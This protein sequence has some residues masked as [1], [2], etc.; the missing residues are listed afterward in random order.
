MHSDVFSLSSLSAAWGSILTRDSS[1]DSVMRFAPNAAEEL[2]RLATS[3]AKKE[4]CPGGLTEI[5]MRGSEKRRIL[6]VPTLRDRIVER[7]ILTAITPWVDPH[8]GAASYAYRPGLGVGHA[9]QAVVELREDGFPWVLRAD[10]DDCF[11]TIPVNLVRSRLAMLVPDNEIMAVIDQLLERT[12]N[13]GAHK[14]RSPHG[15]P[16][17]SALSPMLANLALVDLDDALLAEGFPVV[18]YADD[19]VVATASSEEAAEA[20]YVSQQALRR[21]DMKLGD[22]K[23]GPMS[24]TEGFCFLGEDLGRAIHRRRILNA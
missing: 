5:N 14:S 24:F 4:W 6:H 3:F 12:A 21:L 10:V 13:N 1:S 15:L 20:L 22:D 8:L 11:P 18:R 17:G 16:Q 9:V 2:E 23:T 7:A 19:L